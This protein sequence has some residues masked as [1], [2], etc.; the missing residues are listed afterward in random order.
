M[1]LF[2]IKK[3]GG[4]LSPPLH[5][6]FLHGIIPIQMFIVL[7]ET[8]IIDSENLCL[9]LTKGHRFLF[10]KDNKKIHEQSTDKRV[11]GCMDTKR[12]Y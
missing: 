3:G 7:R 12:N 11:Y 9:C 5:S 10:I 4:E 8:D 2:K 1:T 6:G